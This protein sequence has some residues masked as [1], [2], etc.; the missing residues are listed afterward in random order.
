[1]KK[2]MFLAVIIV[3]MSATYY[4]AIFLP[5]MRDFEM[6]DMCA[7]KAEESFKKNYPRTQGETYGYTCHYNKRLNKCFIEVSGALFDISE[8][9][10]NVDSLFDAYENKT[11]AE[12][13]QVVKKGQHYYD[14]PPFICTMLGKT[15]NS[16]AEYDSFVKPYMEE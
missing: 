8:Q 3:C 5:K 15:C 14:T 4:F 16:K 11:Y 10:S 1:M 2:I 12:Y 9:T 7:K 13:H 6:R